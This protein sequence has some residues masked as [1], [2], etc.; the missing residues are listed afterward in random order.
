MIT[1]QRHLNFR[2]RDVVISN[3]QR[4]DVD[5]QPSTSAPNDNI[6]IRGSNNNHNKA[7]DKSPIQDS[8]VKNI[9]N[10]KEVIIVDKAIISFSFET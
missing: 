7:K 1:F 10:K 4:K 8:H 6:D 5:N 9:E 2:N 3:P